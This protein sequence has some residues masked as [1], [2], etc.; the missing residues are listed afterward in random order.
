MEREYD[1]ISRLA[2]EKWELVEQ[3]E[4]LKLH[5]AELDR[6]ISERSF[7]WTVGEDG[8]VEVGLG[9]L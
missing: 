7:Y 9:V 8:L 6:Q 3:I 1:E 5:E 2:A 4:R